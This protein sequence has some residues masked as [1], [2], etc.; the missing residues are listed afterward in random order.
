[1]FF[2]DKGKGLRYLLSFVSNLYLLQEKK[3]KPKHA[4]GKQKINRKFLVR[5]SHPPDLSPFIYSKHELKVFLQPWFPE[6]GL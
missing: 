1:M 2:M 3:N 5:G 4:I 6:A